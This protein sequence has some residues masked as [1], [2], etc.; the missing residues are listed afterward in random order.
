MTHTHFQSA[1]FPAIFSFGLLSPSNRL[2]P[3]PLT[4]ATANL[5]ALSLTVLPEVPWPTLTARFPPFLRWCDSDRALPS[6]V[7]HGHLCHIP[8]FA[9]I[10]SHPINMSVVKTSLLNY[11]LYIHFLMLM[12]L[13]SPLD[14]CC[15]PFPNLTA[16]TSFPGTSWLFGYKFSLLLFLRLKS[17][18]TAV[19]NVL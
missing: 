10:S 16:M 19:K 5:P 14:S 7:S 2:I 9:L 6:R 1:Q 18:R 12:L 3:C 17:Q 13:P 8:H 4:V 15:P 11:S